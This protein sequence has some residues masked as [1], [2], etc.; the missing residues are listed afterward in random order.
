LVGEKIERLGGGQA[1]VPL[2]GGRLGDGVGDALGLEG[3]FVFLHGRR[4][5]IE[6]E[7][8]VVA[9]RAGGGEGGVLGFDDVDGKHFPTCQHCRLRRGVAVY[10]RVGSVAIV[11]GIQRGSAFGPWLPFDRFCHP[12]GGGLSGVFFLAGQITRIK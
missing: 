3:G 12:I 7:L 2:R 10:D 9:A 4:R 5:E 6:G 1:D 11:D 8:V